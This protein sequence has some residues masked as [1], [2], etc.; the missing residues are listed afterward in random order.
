[1]PVLPWTKRGF[2]VRHLTGCISLPI[3]DFERLDQSTLHLLLGL[4][5]VAAD[6]S[7]NAG[8]AKEGAPDAN[9]ETRGAD[10]R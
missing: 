4:K 8:L 10:D 7:Q 1:M 5:S 2:R 9:G 3:P 6:L